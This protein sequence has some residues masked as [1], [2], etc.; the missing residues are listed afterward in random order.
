MS[1]CLA[2]IRN[3]CATVASADGQTVK[4]AGLARLRR[5]RPPTPHRTTEADEEVYAA[6]VAALGKVDVLCAH[7]PPAIR[8]GQRSALE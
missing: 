6:K 8:S 3:S 7:I 4:L 5:R 1:I 2:S